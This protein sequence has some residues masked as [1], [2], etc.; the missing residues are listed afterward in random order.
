[1][2]YFS[3]LSDQPY[4][5]VYSKDFIEEKSGGSLRRSSTKILIHLNLI[6]F[7]RLSHLLDKIVALTGIDDPSRTID[8]QSAF[9]GDMSRF[10]HFGN[11]TPLR[12][13]T[14]NQQ[15]MLRNLLAYA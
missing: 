4:P 11:T 13:Y 7:C 3:D 9:S 10:H 1:M 8:E 2:D 5:W 15:K 6:V 14:R 12:T